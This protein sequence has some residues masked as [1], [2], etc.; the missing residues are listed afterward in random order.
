MNIKNNRPPNR[1]NIFE[2]IMDDIVVYNKDD[3][4]S[5]FQLYQWVSCYNYNA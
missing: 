1:P 3:V 2:Q 5:D 4:F